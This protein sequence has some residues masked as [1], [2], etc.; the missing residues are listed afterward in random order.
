M[1]EENN[2]TLELKL[3]PEQ[4]AEV[5]AKLTAIS[6]EAFENIKNNLVELFRKVKKI[7]IKNASMLVDGLLRIANE[8]PKWWH[9]YRYSK[10]RRVRKKYRRKLMQQL[11]SKM[12]ALNEMREAI[13]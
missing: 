8:H 11:L 10:K 4:A 6:A 2:V 13:A 1:T 5:G 7:I 9:L 3:T 12:R